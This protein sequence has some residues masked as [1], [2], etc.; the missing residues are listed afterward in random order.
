MQACVL[1]GVA[2]A[3]QGG[4]LYVMPSVRDEH[5][6][7]ATFQLPCLNKLYRWAACLYRLG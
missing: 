5:K 6:L 7:Q 2:A 1:V 3:P 4:R